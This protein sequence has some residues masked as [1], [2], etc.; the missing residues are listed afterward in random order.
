M[1]I[2]GVVRQLPL[3]EPAIDP[4]LLVQATAQGLDLS[5][6]LSDLNAPRPHYRFVHM[7]QRA[8]D[9][10]NDVKAL[11]A[12]LLSALEKRD[13]EVLGLL[14]ATHDTALRRASLETRKQQ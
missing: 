3:F 14:R 1:N 11:G 9:A 4:A 6:V 7:L 8:L 5:S 10:C 13:A 2:S 12:S